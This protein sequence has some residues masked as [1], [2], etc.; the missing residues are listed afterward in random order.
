MRG[1]SF[2]DV[3]TLYNGIWIGTASITSRV[4]ETANLE[5]VE[6]V[7]GPS[8]IMSGLDAIGGSVNYVS[9]QPTTGPVR[10][11]LDLS[12]DTLGTFRSHY[13]SGGSTALPGLD[14]RFDVSSSKI[15]SFIDGDYR[16]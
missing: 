15:N 14:Y 8:S 9:R 12:I 4:M 13:G 11:E 7:Q 2:G 6:F 1:F 10:N 3:T 16:S 5:Q